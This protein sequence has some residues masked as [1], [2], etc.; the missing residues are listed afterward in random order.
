M[1][2]GVKI[3]QTSR[4]PL[5]RLY[6]ENKNEFEIEVRENVL[7]FAKKVK[8]YHKKERLVHKVLDYCRVVKNREIFKIDVSK[9]R[10]VFDLYQ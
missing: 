7:E 10:E 2:K 4:N 5:I 1:C 8:D 6:E 3:G 9:V